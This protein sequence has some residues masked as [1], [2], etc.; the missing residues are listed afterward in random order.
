M[1]EF[2]YIH[3][4]GIG[5]GEGSADQELLGGKGAGLALLGRHDIPVPPGFTIVTDCC[6]HFL[7][8]GSWPEGLKQE[9]EEAL[10]WL[11]Q[12]TDRPF[13]QT[14][15]PLLVSVRSGAA[16]SMPGM[17][18]TLLNVGLNPQAEHARDPRFPEIHHDFCERFKKIAGA[19]PPDSPLATLHACIETVWHSW[20]SSRAQA[21]RHRHGISNFKG[22]AVN[23]QAMFP[24][25][26]SG[27]VFSLDPNDVDKE[28]MVVQAA[29]GLGESVV[30]GDVT[31]DTYRLSRQD[32]TALKCVIGQKSTIV[33]A[34]G[35]GSQHREDDR[36]LDDDQL[37]EL[38]RLC[39]RIEE[40]R[41]QPLD[42]EFGWAG[43]EFAILQSRPIRGLEVA[44][45]VEPA[46]QEMIECLRQKSRPHRKVWVR[47]NL[48]ETL[49]YPTPMTWDLL[50]GF[51][52][53]AGGFGRMYLDFGYNPGLVFREH[54]F[55]ELI[56]GRVFADPDRAVSL[57]YDGM[58]LGY[59][60]EDILENPQIIER[61]PTIFQ[62]E[63]SE[64]NFFLKLPRNIHSMLRAAR[65]LKRLRRDALRRFRDDV[66]PDFLEYVKVERERDLTEPGVQEL[67]AV[68]EERRR[69]VLDQFGGESLKPGFFGGLAYG[70][71]M[72]DLSHIF[73]TEHGRELALRLISGLDEDFTVQQDMGLRK[74]AEGKATMDDFLN[75]FGQRA[76]HEMEL[77]EPRWRENSEYI[78]QAAQHLLATADPHERHEKNQRRRLELEGKL[79]E[80]LARQGASSLFEVLAENLR[81]TQQLLPWRE[82]GKFYLM[83]GYELLREAL[84]ELGRRW[85]IGDDVFYLHL[86]ELAEFERRKKSL[87]QQICLRKTR[88][89]AW[90]RLDMPRVIDS[91]DLNSLG[92]PRVVSPETEL[93]GE[94]ISAGISEGRAR[95]VFDPSQTLDLG[96][97]AILVC[98]STDPSWTSLFAQA[99]GLIIE[100]GGTLSHGAIVAR[101]FGLPAVVCPDA[102]RLIKEGQ[103]IALDGNNGKIA[104]LEEGS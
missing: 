41:E 100:R 62:P 104:L 20:N 32:L 58:P 71:L 55:L 47:H 28:E 72:A 33:R 49:S 6:R 82:N 59:D 5:L 14:E 69:R 99:K 17:M 73:G 80:M 56:G 64:D 1:T 45:D 103:R 42:I 21:Y 44:R 24:S 77:A 4:F 86:A 19:S 38:G 92:L 2:R 51:M 94:P 30:A 3:R 81:Q 88:R 57:F 15:K 31:P 23:I 35:D 7:E 102:T 27:V 98:P 25:E 54:G 91:A 37:R 101:D 10:A 9:V 89:A 43:G 67:L 40:L 12:T 36:C 39:L 53:G 68:F 84:L 18:D 50:E 78:A 29:F 70:E 85:E 93:T 66:L 75:R 96:P 83:M 63:R 34:L 90:R 95:L 79:P 11:E 16:I 13:G 46:R 61:P 8:H 60:A 26:I 48:D 22:T 65:R 76:V 87:R 52:R 97:E 74:V